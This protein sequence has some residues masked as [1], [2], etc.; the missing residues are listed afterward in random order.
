[1]TNQPG[2]EHDVQRADEPA[3]EWFAQ[4]LGEEWETVGDGIYRLVNDPE[5]PAGT[6]GTAAASAERG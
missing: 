6:A 3:G 4:Q 5:P 1:M 2:N